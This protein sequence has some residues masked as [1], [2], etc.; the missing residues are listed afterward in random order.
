MLNFSIIISNTLRSYYYLKAL[1]KNKLC[2]NQIFY[3]DNM[4][5]Q[6][7]SMLIKKKFFFPD[8]K[9][10]TIVSDTV[11]CKKINILKNYN[12]KYI[13][14]S[15]YPGDIMKNKILLKKKKF[16][17]SH[18]GKLPLYK[19]STTI[20]Y[21]L[22]KEKSIYCSTILL[23][24]KLDEGEVLFKKKYPIPKNIN[25]IDLVYDCEIRSKNM[26]KTLKLLNKFKSDKI[27]NKK[28]TKIKTIPYFVMHPVL[29]SLV[30]KYN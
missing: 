24:N 23:N 5:T 9:I 29:R 7:R 21:S 11:N 8:S 26:I 30:L 14:Y 18:P 13:I 25:S 10:I 3:I 12:C 20:Y 1:K 2:P 28:I 19:G 15:S 17:H 16:L 27:K 4:R 22:L 6:Y